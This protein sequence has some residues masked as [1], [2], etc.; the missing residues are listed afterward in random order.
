MTIKMPEQ[1][2]ETL[3]PDDVGHNPWGSGGEVAGAT[4]GRM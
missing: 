3:K 1:S 2:I 4:V